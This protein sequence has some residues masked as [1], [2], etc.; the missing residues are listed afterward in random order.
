MA[1][2]SH[3]AQAATQAIA[4]HQ[5]LL[6]IPHANV[7]PDGLSSALACYQMFREMGKEVTVICPDT[8]PESL[9]FL[10]GYEKLQ[11]EIAENQNFIVT[12]NLAEGV[13]VDKLRYT[14]EDQKVNIIV[15]PKKGK[16]DAT[17]IAFGEGERQYDLIVVVDTADLALL[18]NFYT[19]HIDLF[20]DVPILNIDHHISNTRHGQ[21]Q[22]IDPTAASATEV[23]YTW[24]MQQPEWRDKITPDMATLLLTGLITDTRSFQNPNTTPRSLEVAAEL[25]EKGARQQEIIQHLYKTKPLST[26]KIWGR[27]LNRI[28]MDPVAGIVWS[29]ISREDLQEMGATSKETHGILDEL[30]STIPGADVYVLFTEVEEGGL[31]AST[32]SSSAID[33]SRLAAEAYGG[34]GH[35]RA[36]GFRVKT[37]DNFQLQVLESVQKLK[38]GMKRQRMEDTDRTPAPAPVAPV[39]QPSAPAPIPQSAPD[40]PQA[41]SVDV[42][43]KISG[44]GQGEGKEKDIVEGLT[45]EIEGNKGK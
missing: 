23:L 34:G 24:F 31:K 44:N 14:V 2:S 33:S 11:Q 5:R 12:I 35:P 29:A 39:K 43:Q 37:Y 9:K 22:L 16:I 10:P 20:S 38:E 4:Q 41:P 15:V 21:L 27:A 13:E 32:R 8:P 18:G 3:E 1:L 19:D 36:S 17:H 7:D 26:L 28:Q 42:V 6:V 40:K 30:I 45:G 25:L